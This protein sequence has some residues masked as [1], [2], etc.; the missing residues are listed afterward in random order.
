MNDVLQALLWWG[1]EKKGEVC[2]RDGVV[3][4]WCYAGK[5]SG[6]KIGVFV[7]SILSAKP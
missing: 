2:L 5:F 3:A 4:S 7:T 1:K 6:N